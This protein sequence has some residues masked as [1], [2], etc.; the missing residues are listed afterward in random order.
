MQYAFIVV[1]ITFY[2]SFGLVEGLL[3]AVMVE[4]DYIEEVFEKSTPLF[5]II[6]IRMKRLYF[7][8][9]DKE[10][11][12]FL[13]KRG[14]MQVF[15][16]NIFYMIKRAE[17]IYEGDMEKS[18]KKLEVELLDVYEKQI[19]DKIQRDKFLSGYK[20]WNGS[21]NTKTDRNQKLTEIL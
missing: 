20:Q 12:C 9:I 6:T 10:L 3:G 19:D 4:K 17:V 16:Q 7:S 14:R 8:D 11:Y 1:L 21:V 18:K 13:D 15:E 5:G 2:L